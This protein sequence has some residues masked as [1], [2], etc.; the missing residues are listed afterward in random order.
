[1]GNNPLH[2]TET[3][4]MLYGSECGWRLTVLLGHQIRSAKP[5]QAMIARSAKPMA[6]SGKCETET[7]RKI[8]HELGTQSPIGSNLLNSTA[9]IC[10]V[11]GYLGA[12]ELSRHWY[13]CRHLR[14]K[15]PEAVISFIRS[16]S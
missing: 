4:N 1:M 3:W 5:L 11:T 10:A 2:E 13:Q 12:L 15:S 7:M 6:S 8:L 16:R 14:Y 9:I